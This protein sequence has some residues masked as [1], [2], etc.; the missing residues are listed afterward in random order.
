MAPNQG[1]A[2]KVAVNRSGLSPHVIR[3]WEKRYA[4][5]TPQRTPTNRR[6][7]SDADIQRLSLL[8]QATLA[9]HSI[10]NIASLSTDRLLELVAED[11]ALAP[12]ATAVSRASVDTSPVA[13]HVDGCIAAVERLDAVDLEATLMR[14]RVALS[15]PDFIEQV[16]APLMN[17]IGERWCDG[18]LRIMHEHLATAVVRTLLGGFQEAAFDIAA[19]APTIV[20]TTPAGQLHEIGALM[21]AATAASAGWGV[22]YLGA[23]LPAEDIAAAAQHTHARVVAL[24]LVHP[25]DDPRAEHE[26]TKLRRYLEPEVFLMVGGRAADGYRESLAAIGA[27][28]VPDMPGLRVHLE[29]LRG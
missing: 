1:H 18:S 28:Q 2:I 9:G 20:V 16:I 3:M 14:A 19:S 23:N 5:V 10:G 25:A 26:L 24:S 17:D 7:Y 15:Q 21:V 29:K 22:T 12:P 6:L 11:E 13:V 4:A 8:R 27:I